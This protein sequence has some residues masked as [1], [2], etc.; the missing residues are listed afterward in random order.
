MRNLNR[1]S[2]M[3][4]FHSTRRSATRN[5][6]RTSDKRRDAIFFLDRSFKTV[7]HGVRSDKDEN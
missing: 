2:E 7:F 1:V 3:F 6:R 4:Y 5:P